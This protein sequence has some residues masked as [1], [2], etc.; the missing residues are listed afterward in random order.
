M[1]PISFIRK[2]KEKIL[3]ILKKRNFYK[4]HLI[5]KILFFDLEKKKKKK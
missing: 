1:I 5:D 3:N 4:L 2:N